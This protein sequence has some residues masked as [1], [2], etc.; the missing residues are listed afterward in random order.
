MKSLRISYNAPVVLTFSLI[1]LLVLLL[2]EKITH[3]WFSIGSSMSMARPS[4]WFR[5]FSHVLGHAD[6]AHLT[7][8]LIFI[9]LLGPVLEEKYGSGGLLEMI[10]ITAAVTAILNLLFFH[11]GLFGASGV[12]FMFVLLASLVNFRSGEIPLTF[13]LVALLFMGKEVIAATKPDMVSQFAHLIGGACGSCFG[14]IL[15]KK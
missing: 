12:V 11:T 3:D 8:N 5:L 4:S 1:C 6:A 10:L 7:G 2:G 15:R 14:F 13:I 9:L